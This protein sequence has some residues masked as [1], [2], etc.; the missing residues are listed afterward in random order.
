VRRRA[1]IIPGI[2]DSPASHWQ[3]LWQEADPASFARIELSPIEWNEPRRDRW[4]AAITEALQGLGEGTILV[5][6]S[7]GCLAVAHW[8]ASTSAKAGGALMVSPPD[9][10]RPAFPQ[11]ALSFSPVPLQP[12]PFPSIVVASS[13]DPYLSLSHARVCAESWRGTLHVAGARGHLSA[14]DGLGDWPAGRALFEQ[15]RHDA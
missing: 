11:Q 12:L 14:S 6:H 15:L 4:V 9:P 3:T 7:L 1:L 2:G 10:A 5:A 8:A 13:N